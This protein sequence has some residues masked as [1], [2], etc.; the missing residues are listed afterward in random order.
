MFSREPAEA[1]ASVPALDIEDLRLSFEVRGVERE[2]VAGVSLDRSRRGIR[3][4]RR[5]G[6]REVDD[7]VRGDRALHGAQ[8]AHHQ[9]FDPAGRSRSAGDAG[10]RPRKLR[11]TSV[12]MVYQNP[13]DGAEPGDQ[14]RRAGR[15]GFRILGASKDAAA[16]QTLQDPDEGADLRPRGRGPPVPAPAVGRH[17]AARGDRDGVGEGPDAADPRRADDRTGRDRRGRGAGPGVQPAPRV[18]HRR[19][20]HL[21]QPGRGGARVRPRGGPVCG[22][23]GRGVHH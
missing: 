19:A 17:A 9:R 12:S 20:V 21:A 14:G 16:A 13:G 4:G 7:R 15:R 10:G 22:P 6:L 1:P 23:D 18:R 5:V 8:R 2:A 3:L 11:Q